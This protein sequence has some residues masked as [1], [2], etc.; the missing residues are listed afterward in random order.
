MPIPKPR[1]NESRQ[2]FLNRCMGDDTM[3]DE[4]NSNQRLAVCTNEYDSK[5]DSIEAEEKREIRKDVFDNPG[6]ATA[7]AKELGCE[8]IHTH[9][10]DG[11]TIYMPCKTHADYEEQT[12]E[13]LKDNIAELKDT[14]ELK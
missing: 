7:R 11:K 2:D 9:D 5:E 8:G 1:T 3:V 12:G 6:E 4:Y 13:Q 10:E 14:I